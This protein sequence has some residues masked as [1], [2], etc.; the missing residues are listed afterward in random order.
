MIDEKE[1]EKN[2]NL[3]EKNDNRQIVR[4]TAPRINNYGL[5]PQKAKITTPHLKYL[6]PPKDMACSNLQTSLLK[7]E[8]FKNKDFKLESRE[9]GLINVNKKEHQDFSEY[10]VEGF[11]KKERE[12]VGEQISLL[13]QVYR[14]LDSR[15]NEINKLEYIPTYKRVIYDSGIKKFDPHYIIFWFK[16]RYRNKKCNLSS[17]TE[18]KLRAGLIKNAEIKDFL[19]SKKPEIKNLEFLPTKSNIVQVRPDFKDNSRLNKVICEW[20]QQNKLPSITKLK[21]LANQEPF[22]RKVFNILDSRKKDIKDKNFLPTVENILNINNEFDDK[23]LLREYINRWLKKN[24]IA[25]NLKAY[26][27]NIGIKS[28]A[29]ALIDFF[30]FKYPAIICG[31]YFPT[32]QN[33]RKDQA[34]IGIDINNYSNLDKIRWNWFNEKVGTSMSQLIEDFNPTYDQL[35]VKLYN[36]YPPKFKSQK[37]RVFNAIFQTVMIRSQNELQKFK[38]T[39]VFSS[40]KSFF[41]YI[42]KNEHWKFVDVLTGE[43]FTLQNYLYHEIDLHHINFIRT[44]L[45]PDNLV[46]LFEDNHH[47]ITSAKK[48]Y[49][50]LYEFLT[51]LLQE[52]LEYLEQNKIPRSW[53]VGWRKLASQ[54]G[55]NLP[56]KRYQKNTIRPTILRHF[57]SQKKLDSF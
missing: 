5:A 50:K 31:K 29:R 44:D 16:S 52:N 12:S 21:E 48:Y 11:E 17:L 14:F 40:F 8:V 26:L 22:M 53:K 42:N 57:Q 13:E 46:F 49:E 36:G 1:V 9:K 32:I 35:G 38:P 28:S 18:L 41:N 54:E 39:K 47:Q 7:S 19:D 55:I 20:L 2:G 25:N 33:L 10:K 51:K 24:N 6:T 34:Q 30:N 3:E 27:Y 23:V 37:F 56:V 4:V 15:L 45:G 43:I